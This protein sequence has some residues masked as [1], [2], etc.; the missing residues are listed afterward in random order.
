MGLSEPITSVTVRCVH[1]PSSVASHS[2]DSRPVRAV[3]AVCPR[4]LR[5]VCRGRQ[6]A[7]AAARVVGQGRVRDIVQD[8]LARGYHGA[9]SIEP[10][11]IVVYHETGAKPVDEA[12]MRKNY[13]EYG[14]RLEALLRG[15]A[16]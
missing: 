14:R 3:P 8:A 9:F 2:S 6:R 5:S 11:M 7:A 1:H 15:V 13:V 16:A 12:V 10:H 4:F